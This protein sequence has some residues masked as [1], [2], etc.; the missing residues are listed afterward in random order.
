VDV[1]P[2]IFDTRNQPPPNPTVAAVNGQWRQLL[3]RIASVKAKESKCVRLS[4]GNPQSAKDFIVFPH[5]KHDEFVIRDHSR[6]DY[7]SRT[8]C[9]I[10][11][12]DQEVGILDWYQKEFF[13]PMATLLETAIKNGW[14]VSSTFYERGEAHPFPNTKSILQ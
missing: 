10:L 2:P 8:P 1:L 9:A 14:G 13:S 7:C 6:C 11:A 3:S 12:A 5:W 4:N